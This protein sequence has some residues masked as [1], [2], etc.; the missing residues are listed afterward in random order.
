MA[1][2]SFRYFVNYIC[3]FYIVVCLPVS[4]LI[5]SISLHFPECTYQALLWCKIFSIANFGL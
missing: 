1:L 3:E 2:N 5:A 4:F